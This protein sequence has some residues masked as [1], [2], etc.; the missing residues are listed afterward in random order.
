MYLVFYE[1]GRR[2]DTLPTDKLNGKLL[3]IQAVVTNV[4]SICYDKG[5]RVVYPRGTEYQ[6]FVTDYLHAHLKEVPFDNYNHYELDIISTVNAFKEFR[7][8]W[9]D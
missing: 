1:K 7:M 4:E 3:G 5:I 9:R 8:G 2:Q 6:S